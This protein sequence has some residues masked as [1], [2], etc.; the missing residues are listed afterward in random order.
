[1]GRARTRA[2][3]WVASVLACCACAFALN[4]SLDVSQYAHTAWKVRDGFVKGGLTSIA[5]TPDGYLWLG[6]EFGLVRFDGVRAAPWRPPQ[7]QHL[8]PGTIFSLLVTQDGTLWI[9]AKG[10]ASWKDGKLTRYPELAEHFVF[11]LREDREGTV[12]VA[13]AAV[14][15]APGKLCAIRSGGVNCHGDDGGLGD[16]VAALYEDVKGNLWVGVRNGLW[17]WKP[18]PPKFYSLPPAPNGIQAISED[19]DGSLLL[20][21]KD[22]IYRFVD[23]QTHAYSLQGASPQFRAHKTLRDRNGGLWIGT[24]VGGLVHMH[25]GRTDTFLPI[26]GLSGNAVTALFEDREGSIWVCTEGG[27]D[28]FR[29]FAVGTFTVKQRLTNDLVGSVLAD[30]DGGL[31]LGTYDGLNRWEHGQLTIPETGSARRDGKL[32]G[33]YGNSL[34]QDERGR[35]WVSTLRELGYLEDGR[36]TSIKGVPGGNMLSIA[37]DSGGNVWVI[38]EHVGLFRISPQND[39]Q[40]IPWSDLG[41]KDHA[42][43]LTSDRTKGGLWIGFFLGGIAYF[44]DGQVRAYYTAPDGLGAG[45]VSDFHFD[46]DGTLWISTEGGLS[47]LRNNRVATL[48]SKNGLPCDT[49]HWAME[50]DDRSF[51]LYT[52]CGLVRIA[53]SELDAWAADA[54]TKQ[55][56]TR[57]IRVTVFDSSDGVRSLP[58][59]GHYHPLVA[60]TP[61]GRLWFLPWDGVSVIDPRH[62]PINRVPP[63]VHIEK[64]AADGKTYDASNAVSLPAHVRDVSIDYTALSLVDPEKIHF[65]YKLEGQ[66]PDWREVVNDRQVQYSNL[67]P[68]H[69]TFR[70][71]AC[72]NSG[73]WNEA[74]TFLDFSIAPAYYQ[75]TWFRVSC[76]AVLLVLLWGIYRLRVRELQHEFAIGLEARVNERTRIARELHDTLLQNFHGLMFQFQAA[77]NLMLR[78][79][80]EAKRSLDDAIDETKK[81]LAES[82]DAIQGL[83]SE[84]IAEGNIAE[85][86]MSTS[87]ELANA[88]GSEHQ[89]VFDL[90]EEGE[91]RT[92]SPTVSSDICRIALELMRNAYQHAHASRIEAEIRYG[93]SMFRL[94]IRDDGKGIEPKVLKEGGRVGHWGLRGLRERADRIGA[95]LDLWSEPGRGTE[96]QLLVPA[97]VAYESFRDSYRAKLVQK[98]KSR[99]HRS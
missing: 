27:L 67:A 72:N 30:R 58:H 82:R 76:V 92:L 29:D 86:L 85:L 65:R 94:R 2:G 91:R 75:T 28:R 73:V 59:A 7:N 95:H 88:D 70:V 71:M 42:S 74:G 57:A 11:A 46:D 49:V 16:L 17:R 48:T 15:P 98:V 31:W 8:P 62:L 87:R 77:S 45:S 32:N 24:E 64:I 4:P 12:W 66:D 19:H 50:D 18:G 44:S 47:R 55:N 35:I 53:R 6:T 34:F 37:Q 79:P 9:G 43:V 1:M 13:G 78:R 90:V 41:H 56:A 61:D 26:D 89:P 54:E 5:Q 60:K 93:D 83:R 99:A 25:R 23:G 84:P 80:D 96:V 20:G 97:S 63:P 40:H 3:F 21:W 52:A 14:P 10:L 69:Y 36:F 39:V 33:S 81:A 68:R 51:W 22:G 38:N